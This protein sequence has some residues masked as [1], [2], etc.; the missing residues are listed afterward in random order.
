MLALCDEVS[1]RLEAQ[2]LSA[3]PTLNHLVQTH[4][5]AAADE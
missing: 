1:S 2:G 5:R 3:A 4:E